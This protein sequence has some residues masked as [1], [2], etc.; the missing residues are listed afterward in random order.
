MRHRYYDA[1]TLVQ[2]FGKPDLFITMTC[3]PEWKEIRNELKEG[4]ISQDRPDLT[5]RIFRVKL[6]NLKDQLFKKKIFE[7]VAAHIH[8]IEF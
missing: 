3:N 7:K 6:Y 8:V 4:Q 2:Q 5:S 1:M